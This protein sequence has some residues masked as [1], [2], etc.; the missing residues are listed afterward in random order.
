MKFFGS[1]LASHFSEAERPDKKRQ[2]NA[3]M[4]ARRKALLRSGRFD[5]A[6]ALRRASISSIAA[7]RNLNAH[8]AG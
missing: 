3:A 6:A 5:Q 7:R 2:Q 1:V 8:S 4:H